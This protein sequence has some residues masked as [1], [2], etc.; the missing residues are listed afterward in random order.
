MVGVRAM[1]KERGAQSA[2]HGAWGMGHGA[3]PRYCF[4]YVGTRHVVSLHKKIQD[5]SLNL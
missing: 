2:E 5:N 1:G 3:Q 4:F